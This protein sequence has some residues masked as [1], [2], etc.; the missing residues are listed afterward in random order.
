VIE[1]R[2]AACD[3]ERDPSGVGPTRVRSLRAQPV[4]KDETP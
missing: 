1:P 3:A 2:P 4:N